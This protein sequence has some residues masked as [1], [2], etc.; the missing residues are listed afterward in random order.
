MSGFDYE[1][2]GNVAPLAGARIEIM[3]GFDYEVV[4]NVAPLAGA[5]I[6]IVIDA[7]PTAYDPESLP[8]RERGL[9]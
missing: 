8:L 7:Q 2:V 3:S 9:K 4:G 5:R 1:V 6:E